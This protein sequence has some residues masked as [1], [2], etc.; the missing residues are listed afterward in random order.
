MPARAALSVVLIAAAVGCAR[1]PPGEEPA[2]VAA[3]DP[4]LVASASGPSPLASPPPVDV[5]AASVRPILAKTC[6]PCH[7][8]Q[9]KM[10]DKLPFDNARVVASHPEGVLKRLKGSEKETVERWLTALPAELRASPE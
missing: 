1:P 8:P 3:A 5:F 10:Y 4:S 2:R 7:E 6:A 9:G